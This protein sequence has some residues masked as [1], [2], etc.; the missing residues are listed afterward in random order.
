MAMSPLTETIIES[1]NADRILFARQLDRLIG[2]SDARRY[3]LVNRALKANELLKVRRGLYVLANKYR[4]QPVH[5]FV[6]AQQCVP[7]SYV[8]AESALSFHGWIPEAVRSVLSVT[9]SGKSVNYEHDTLGKF[10]FCRMTVNPG[11]FLESVGRHELQNQV[12]LIAEPLRALMDLVYL[13]KLA[14]QG[15]SFLL[16]G[17]RLD[18]QML[19]AVCDS[20]IAILLET[21]SGKREQNFLEELARSLD[22]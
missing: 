13:R 1:G 20:D 15:I 3:G 22:L 8:S 9:A 11:Y 10:E 4:H 19:S 14:W 12:A 2:G 17:L 21:Y 16:S 5:P 18:E 6:L 7:S